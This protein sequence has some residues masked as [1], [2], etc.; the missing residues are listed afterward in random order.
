MARKARKRPGGKRGRT[1]ET[2]GLPG[3]LRRQMTAFGL[4]ALGLALG[5]VLAFGLGAHQ[6]SPSLAP[7]AIATPQEGEEASA[8]LPPEPTSAAL[9]PLPAKS[10]QPNPPAPA[11]APKPMPAPAP[12]SPPLSVASAAAGGGG[13]PAAPLWLRQSVAAPPVQGQA[14]VAIVLDDVGVAPAQAWA[15]LDLPAPM[16]ISIMT[17][18]GEATQLAAEA[19]RR[20]HELMVHMPMEP[21]DASLD[22]GPQALRVGLAPGE[23]LR[24]VDWGLSRFSGYIGFNNHMGSRFTQDAVGMR[25]VLAEA[26]RR[27]LLFLDSKTIS[28]SVAD[29]LAG[30][31]GLAHVAR[32]VFLDDDMSRAAIDRQLAETLRIARRQGSAIAI[33]H[34]HPETLAALKAWL[35]QARANGIVIVPLSAIA[36]KRLGIGE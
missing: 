24:R 18:A 27:G 30:E 21:I 7:V 12:I 15:A 23:I 33:G 25:I 28:S 32:D 36:R 35:P 6:D 14:M 26:K 17:Y 11:V 1:V 22:P 5:W 29:R 2:T 10:A 19:H 13:D 8:P 34:P 3:F 16:T 31:I 20:G 9:A 4:V